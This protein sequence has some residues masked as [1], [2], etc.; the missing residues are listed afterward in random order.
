MP[1]TITCRS[2][3]GNRT[4]R[5][6]QEWDDFADAA[7]QLAACVEELVM[8]LSPRLGEAEKSYVRTLLAETARLGI[9]VVPGQATY[10]VVDVTDAPPFHQ[11]SAT[12][13]HSIDWSAVGR[14]AR[15][16]QRHAIELNHTSSLA[17]DPDFDA[18]ARA[19]ATLGELIDLYIALNAHLR[20]R[21]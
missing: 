17:P 20:P 4:D 16:L 13:P 2:H 14:L 3:D 8:S 19:R 5:H 1:Y 15:R 18:E 10:Q 9:A 6:S 7:R 11:S 12:R 21:R